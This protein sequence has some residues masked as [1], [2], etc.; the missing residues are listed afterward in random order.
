MNCQSKNPLLPGKIEGESR[1]VSRILY[2]DFPP[3]GGRP[4]GTAVTGGL[5]RPTRASSAAGHSIGSYLALL[6]EGFTKP[7]P[8]PGPLVGSYPTFSPS[9]AAALSSES[10][11]GRFPFLRHF[12]S[13]LP[14]WALPSSLP[15][16][17]R[18]FLER[19]QKAAPATTRPALSVKIIGW[20][21]GPRQQG[22]PGLALFI[23][24]AGG[25][26][27]LRPCR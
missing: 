3:G 6:R 4:S 17:V 9:P 5:E 27:P 10:N 13:G 25:S 11:S 18:T 19:G 15:C 8:S 23:S 14:A 16:G 12:P 7:A 24:R 20:R 2:P 22:Y 1:P 21:T 26:P